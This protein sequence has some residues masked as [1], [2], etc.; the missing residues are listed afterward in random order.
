MSGMFILSCI[1][2]TASSAQSI[3]VPKDKR[4]F[5]CFSLLIV[6]FFLFSS[7]INI[8]FTKLLLFVCFYIP[9]RYALHWVM[10]VVRERT[11]VKLNV[12]KDKEKR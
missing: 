8:S 3:E 1:T 11:E 10:I 12:C 2:K 4:H 6:C 7:A 9:L 5:P